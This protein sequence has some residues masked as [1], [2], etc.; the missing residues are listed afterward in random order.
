MMGYSVLSRSTLI[1]GLQLKVRGMPRR[2]SDDEAS[3][4]DSWLLSSI[5]F[6][7]Y[8]SGEQPIKR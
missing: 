6:I 3:D 7:A 2:T 4:S 5:N 1:L 8:N